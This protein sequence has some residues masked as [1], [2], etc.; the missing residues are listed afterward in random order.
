MFIFGEL[1]FQ[2]MWLAGIGL[3][4]LGLTM[5]LRAGRPSA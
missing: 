5:R 1:L 2:L 4:G 3:I